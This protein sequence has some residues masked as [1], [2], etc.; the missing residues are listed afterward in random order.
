MNILLIA[1]YFKPAN[2]IGSKR[3]TEFYNLSIK[4]NSLNFTVL[5]ANWEG[6]KSNT[7]NIHYLGEVQRFNPRSSFQKENSIKKLLHPTFFFRSIDRSSFS[8]WINS[9]KAWIDKNDNEKFDIVISSYNPLSCISIGQ[10]AKKI[11]KIPSVLDLRDLISIQGQKIRLPLVDFIDRYIDKFATKSV[12]SFITVSPTCKV[13]AEDFYKKET[14]LI[15]NGFDRLNVSKAFGNSPSKKDINILY[16]GT[17]GLNRS[18]LKI[19]EL[20][21]TFNSSSYYKSITINFA[22][23]DDPNDFLKNIKLEHLKVKWLGYLEPKQLIDQKDRADILLLLEDQSPKGNEN[24]TG[25]LFEYIETGKPVLA[26]CH[27]DSDIGLV[28]RDINLGSIVND[29]ESLYNF[30]QLDFK[31]NS[32][33]REKYSRVNQ[34]LKLKECINYLINK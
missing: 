27:V 15:F 23:K 8:K 28:L 3:W 7:G 5:T 10:Y 4:D 29:M 11:Y 18:P 34:Y 24:L 25:K 32:V 14:F 22:S 19:L 20:L 2:V 13:K 17:L 9:C 26:S 6:E 31:P 16:T 33:N 12:D 30:M 1:Y 21:N